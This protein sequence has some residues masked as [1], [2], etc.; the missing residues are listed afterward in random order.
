M[1][2]ALQNFCIIESCESERESSRG[3][4]GE[5][6]IEI[7]QHAILFL[8]VR[9]KSDL[10]TAGASQRGDQTDTHTRRHDHRGGAITARLRELI[11]A[12]RASS[13]DTIAAHL[14]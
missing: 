3:A 7:I 5:A 14:E 13:T 2:G 1:R 8:F 11:H 6:R 10:I 12:Q 9:A 4:S